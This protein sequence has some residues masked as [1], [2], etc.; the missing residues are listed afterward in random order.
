MT[1]LV[2]T[3]TEKNV[4]LY[5]NTYLCTL[6]CECVREREKKKREREREMVPITA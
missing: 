1:Y 3:D 4:S 5:I 6:D 2:F